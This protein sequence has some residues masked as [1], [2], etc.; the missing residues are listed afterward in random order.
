MPITVQKWCCVVLSGLDYAGKLY[1]ESSSSTFLYKE[2]QSYV[3]VHLSQCL[4]FFDSVTT[5]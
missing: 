3:T 5:H 2:R 4:P 1:I